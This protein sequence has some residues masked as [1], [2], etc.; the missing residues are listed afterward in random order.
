MNN[1]VLMTSYIV[2]R[3]RRIY[4]MSY[5][6]TKK[7]YKKSRAC[8]TVGD[9]AA[10]TIVQLAGGTFLVALMTDLGLSDGNIGIMASFASIAAMAQ[11]ISMKLAPKLKKNKL[12][13][14]I[15]V[16][17]KAWLGF[18]FFIPLLP[19]DDTVKKWLAMICYCFG[20]SCIQI[21]LPATIDW[22]AS[23]MPAKVRGRYFAFKD[24]VA[25]FV[26]VTTMLIMGIMIDY[27]EKINIDYAFIILGT[28]II[29]CALINTISFSKMKEP[30]ISRLNQSGKE[31]HG[32]LAKKSKALEGKRNEDLSIIKE[33][34]AALHHDGFKKALTLN[35]IW[36]TAFYVAL[37]FNA[38]YQIKELGLPYTYIMI[39]SFV[40]SMLRIYLTPRAG[41]MADKVGMAKVLRLALFAIS[42]HYIF[43]M[44]SVPGN[45][46]IMAAFAALFSALGWIF[47]GIGLLGIQLE[48]L[49]PENRIVQYSLLCIISG[50]FGFCV[51]FIGGK[52]INYLQAQVI[53][54]GEYRIYAQQITNLIGLFFIGITIWYLK[55]R[56]E[57][58][59]KS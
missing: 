17:Q 4:F 18:I 55:T 23:L 28:S 1:V 32:H 20:Q 6:E 26:V 11:L 50:I 44:I 16:L 12:F 30:R 21:A 2:G 38:S 19:I 58:V 25:T 27:V 37:P 43:M 8:Y 39:L 24:A 48:F 53:M 10:Q 47:I 46:Y 9:T 45:A 52:L 42:W 5:P 29:V 34:I 7:D 15:M 3:M 35:C 51:S 49:D 31:L 56:V 59:A 14:C 13:V 41:K 33:A 57:T 36:M 54:I 22:I 40:A